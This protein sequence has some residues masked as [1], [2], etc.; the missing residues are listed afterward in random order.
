MGRFASREGTHLAFRGVAARS[1]NYPRSPWPPAETART[2]PVMTTAALLLSGGESSRFGGF[3]KALLS[4]GDETIVHR[5]ARR[6]LERGFAPVV[7]VAGAHH[8]PVAHAVRD[9]GVPVVMAENWREGRTASMQAGL[10]AIPPECDLVFWP[11]DHPFVADRTVDRLLAARTADPLAVW[12]L[13]EHE[14]RGGHPVLWRSGVRGDLLALRPDAPIRS[15]I[16]EFGPQVRRVVVD[17]PGVLENV[18]T[19]DEFRAA[20]DAWHAR[21]GD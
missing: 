15:L 17:D 6:C 13:P 12:F 16:P 1:L 4:T 10:L 18:D 19:P 11:I 9:L 2:A 21:G 8:G 5:L 7:V 20:L 14:G 3:P